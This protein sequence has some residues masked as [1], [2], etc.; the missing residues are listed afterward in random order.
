[1]SITR[2]IYV[3]LILSFAAGINAG[4]GLAFFLK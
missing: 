1:M 2:I 4:L 3:G